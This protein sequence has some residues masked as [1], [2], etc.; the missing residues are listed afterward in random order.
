MA[1]LCL[2]GFETQKLSATALQCA[3]RQGTSTTSTVNINTANPRSGAACAECPPSTE[4]RFVHTLASPALDRSYFFRQAIRFAG[5]VAPN[6]NLN[7]MQAF[8]TTTGTVIQINMKETTGEIVV[9]ANKEAK[10]IA[11]SGFAPTINTWYVFELKVLIPTAGKGKVKLIIRNEVGTIIYESAEIEVEVGNL[12]LTSLSGGH[13]TSGETKVTVLLDDWAINDSTGENQNGFPGNAKVVFLKPVA[14]KAR[15]GWTGGAGAT[16]TL[17]D[18]VNNTPP[19]GKKVAEGTDASQI[20]DPNNNSTDTYEA[21]LAAYSTPVENGGGGIGGGDTVKVVS[22]V[23]RGGQ[24]SATARGL[25]ITMNSNPAIGESTQGLQAAIA[26]TETVGWTTVTMVYTYNPTV[27]IGVKPVLKLRKSVATTD[28]VMADLLGL[29]VEY[30]PASSLALGASSGVASATLALTAP[31]QVP[32]GESSGVA[33]ASLA[34]TAPTVVPLEASSGAASTS[35]ALTSP[36]R[37]PLGASSGI[38]SATLALTAPTRVALGASSGAASATLALA[39]RALVEL[40]ASSGVAS[41]SLTLTART[42]VPLGASSGASST[43]LALSAKTSLPLG[44][45]SGVASASLAVTLPVI[46]LALQPSDGKSSTSL[47]IRLPRQVVLGPSHGVATAS[48]F[49][50]YPIPSSHK[51]RRAGKWVAI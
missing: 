26:E 13:I 18:A 3:E 30:I 11:T 50:F 49:I 43:S 6:V 19:T 16:T 45:S 31:T 46:P 29:Y 9:F 25:G 10:N 41:A 2:V 20:K 15:T 4:G 17:W 40:G 22:P 28:T 12:V 5:S 51:V 36:T 33:S 27:E 39:A 32:L 14:D 37:V 7:L 1:R 48:A 47:A 35:L 42:A 24:S 21:E 8:A 44:A 38:A 23:A 34:L